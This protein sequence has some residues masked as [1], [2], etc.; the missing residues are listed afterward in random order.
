MSHFQWLVL[1][2]V[3]VVGVDFVDVDVIRCAWS[4]VRRSGLEASLKVGDIGGIFSLK[5]DCRHQLR[6]DS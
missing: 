5:I 1:V 3:D 6:L 4:V 2:A